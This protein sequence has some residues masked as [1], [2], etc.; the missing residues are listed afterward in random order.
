MYLI[1][2]KKELIFK[3][4]LI[5]KF[6]NKINLNFNLKLNLILFYT[7][8]QIELTK[9]KIIKLIIKKNN[10]YNLIN[11]ATFFEN[12]LINFK[13]KLNFLPK[14]NKK[15]SN[16]NF[17]KSVSFINKFLFYFIFF[18]LNDFKQEF[19]IEKNYKNFNLNFNSEI[20]VLL[21]NISSHNNGNIFY[22]SK[23]DWTI[24]LFCNLIFEHIVKNK[25]NF[26]FLNLYN[27]NLNSILKI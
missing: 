10:I 3:N 17:L 6:Q 12:I 13:P 11:S 26:I 15:V 7:N 27:L 4:L 18:K 24:N 23:Q 20:V 25:N 8:N 2:L 1:E 19:L 16:K 14:V 5:K 9:F 21:K 22:S